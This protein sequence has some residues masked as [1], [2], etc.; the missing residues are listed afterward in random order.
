MKRPDR[1]AFLAA[2][3]AMAL[4]PT[5]PQAAPMIALPSDIV[6]NEAATIMAV[7]TV[8]PVVAMTFDDGP[9]PRLTPL[10]LDMLKARGLRA[11]FY[12]IGNRVVKWPDIVKRIA[13]EGHE[14]GNHSWSHPFLSK[15]GND[16]VLSE[17]DRTTD[18]IYKVTGRPPVTF[19]PPYGAFTNKQRQMLYQ[20][21]NLPTVLWSVDPQDWRKP[22][23]STVAKRILGGSR[24]G[25]IILS[26]DIHT[27]TVNAMP[28]TLDG[29]HERGYQ[30]GTVSQIMGW[31]LWQSR[32]FRRVVKG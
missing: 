10:L 26:H 1:R 30:L 23:A 14:I 32:S 9:H 18:A 12:L 27:G 11:T 5:L 3:G 22:G 24:P 2:C 15:L 13:D 21:R 7:R 28:G 17:I 25:A 20:K 4:C 8:S 31:P 19:R 16:A 29:L 6:Q